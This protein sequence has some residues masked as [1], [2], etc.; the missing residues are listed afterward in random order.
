M[1]RP[2]LWRVAGDHQVFTT[3]QHDQPIKRGPALTFG[4]FLPDTHHFAGRGGRAVPLYASSDTSRPNLAPGLLELLTDRLGVPVTPED[5]LAYTAAVTAHPSFH[6]Y[7]A[8]DL[9]TP[10][11]RV[12]LTADRE[13]WE[14]AVLLGRRVLWLHAQGE[15]F[16]SPSDGRPAGP[17]RVEGDERPLVREAITPEPMPD[18]MEYDAVTRELRVGDG[19]VA[20]VDPRVVAYE[21][22]GMNVLRKWFGYR[23]ATRPQARGDQSPLDD[24]RPT[25]WPTEYTTDLL[26]LLNVLTL[27]VEAEPAQAAL[28]DRVMVG[29]RITVS[30]L[31]AEGVLPVPEASRSLPKQADEDPVQQ[32]WLLENE[33]RKGSA[34]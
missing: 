32:L 27:V 8:D 34:S 9:R 18:E 15:R 20:P 14:D 30:D 16:V 2:N 11:I 25:T 26:D 24:V 19:V 17:P 22:S 33:A 23:R 4:A 13:S 5:F 7:F 1:P 3:E 28:L 6:D 12:P 21:V 29:P 31:T 10:G